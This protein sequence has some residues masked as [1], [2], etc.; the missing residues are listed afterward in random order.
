MQTREAE[1]AAKLAALREAVAVGIADIEAGRYTDFQD[2]SSL[3]A[4]I[5]RI[6]RRVLAQQG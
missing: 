1:R 6:G 4:H 5:K 2:V 3:R